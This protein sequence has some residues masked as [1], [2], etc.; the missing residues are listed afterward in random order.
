M[1]IKFML[2]DNVFLNCTDNKGRFGRNL[3]LNGPIIACFVT[4][5]TSLNNS[6]AYE[7]DS[8]RFY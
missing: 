5:N 6:K 4:V 1:H 7:M 2:D 8:V 3:Y